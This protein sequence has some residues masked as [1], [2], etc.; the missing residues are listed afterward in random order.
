M[1]QRS[2][3]IVNEHCESVFNAAMAE[4][5][6][7]DKAPSICRAGTLRHGMWTPNAAYTPPTKS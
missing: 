7:R 4:K 3:H 2:L 1:R 6:L 5:A